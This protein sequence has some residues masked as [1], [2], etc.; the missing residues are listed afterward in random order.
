VLKDFCSIKKQINNT[1]TNMKKFQFTILMMMLSVIT[2][3]QP[4]QTIRGRVTDKITKTALPGATVVL[5]NSNPLIGTATNIDGDFRLEKVAVGRQSISISYIGYKSAT[6]QNLIVN[7][8]KEVVIEVELEENVIEGAEVEI[9]AYSLKDETINRMV[10]VSARSFSVEETEKF[11]GSRGDVARM[12]MNFAGVSAANDQRNDI[13]IR[14]N[15]PSGLLWRLED[16]DIPNPNHFA[17]NG[18][19]GGPVSMLNNNLLSNSDFFTGAFPAEYGNAM[20]GVFDLRMR[21]GNN[22]KHEFLGQVGFNGFELGAEGPINRNKKSSYL[23][24]FRYSTLELMDKFMDLGTTGVP[25]YKDL[26]FKLNFPVKKGNISVFGLAGTS[27]IDILD[28]KNGNDQDLYSNEGQDLYNRSRM[29]TSGVTYTRFINART[30]YKLIFSGVFQD[31]GTIIDTLDGAGIPHPNIDHNYA[32]YKATL[33]GFIHTKYNS[34]LSSRIGFVADRLGFDLLSQEWNIE[35]GDYR[36]M[37]DFSKRLEDGVSLYQGYAQA[38]Y[39]FNDQLSLIPGV[40]FT[41]ADLNKTGSVEPRLGLNWQLSGN[42]KLSFGYGLHSKTQ[43][44]STYFLGTW[45]DDGT[46]TETNKELGFTRSHEFVIGYDRYLSAN[47]RFKTEVYYQDIFDVPV[48]ERSTSFS[49]LN[50]GA[51]WGVGAQDSLV[52]RGTG[53][54]YGLE[55]TLERTF[56]RNIYYLT[57]LSL[58][59]S[60]YKG[61]DNIERS[62]AFNGNYVL[63]ALVGKEFTLSNRAAFLID[64]KLTFAGGKCYTPVNLEASQLAG[65]TK[66]DDTKAF[67]EQFDP[68][69]KADIKFGYRVNGKKISQEWQFYIENFTDHDNVLAQ[70]YSKSKNEITEVYQLGFFPMLQY[71]IHF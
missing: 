62:T 8:A 39:S 25:K 21:N 58:F 19:T 22:E 33:S 49:M 10:A 40:H 53:K 16:V 50:T 11:A 65:E 64:F 59:E 5:L 35:D 27:E 63:N 38:I 61:S 4:T 46:L 54:N 7:S 36:P 15:S 44:L 26:S 67:S 68:F 2:W 13:I 57:T 20:S 3:A 24:N 47:T 29:L 43:V 28:S 14:G 60:K 70:T 23:A 42:Q 45:H 31:G 56:S 34:H 32:E 71:R 30:Y 69:F 41:Y 17:E 48:E 6:Y 12:A 18:T 1:F 55:F 9:K 37:I 51:S 66:Y 52:N